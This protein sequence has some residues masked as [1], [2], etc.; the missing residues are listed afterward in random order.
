MYE[1]GFLSGAICG[2]TFVAV[3]AYL[4]WPRRPQPTVRVWPPQPRTVRVMP[5]QPLV[6]WKKDRLA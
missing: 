2:G 6:D 4:I 3:L 1:I 5:R